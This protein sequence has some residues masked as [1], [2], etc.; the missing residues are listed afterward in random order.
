MDGNL[1]FCEK[2]LKV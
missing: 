1:R 2:Q